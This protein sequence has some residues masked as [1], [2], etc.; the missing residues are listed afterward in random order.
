MWWSTE[1][2]VTKSIELSCWVNRAIGHIAAGHEG[3]REKLGVAGAC[4]NIIIVLQKHSTNMNIC[5]EVC[6]AI[7][8][9]AQTGNKLMTYY[10]YLTL[11]YFATNLNSSFYPLLIS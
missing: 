5:T 9:M 10:F 8:N 6:W 4:E 7:R 3:N 11:F 2:I 1:F